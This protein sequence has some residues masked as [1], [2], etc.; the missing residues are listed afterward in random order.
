LNPATDS[1]TPPPAE[2]PGTHG[3]RDGPLPSNWREALLGLIASRVALIQLESKEAA[4]DGMRR[5]IRIVAIV[6]CAFFTWALVLAGGIAAIANATTWPWYW[7]AMIAA[8]VHLVVAIILAR[9]VKSPD[10]PPFPVTRAEFQKDREWI[11]NFQKTRKS[12]V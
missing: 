12:N 4:G 8:A 1:E 6:I 11:E 5:A 2:N 9:T 7:I 10:H 3:G